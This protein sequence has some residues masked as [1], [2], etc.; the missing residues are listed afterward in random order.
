MGETYLS[1]LACT[2]RPNWRI[3]SRRSHRGFTHYNPKQDLKLFSCLQLA[4]N[5]HVGAVQRP[6]GVPL[7]N[8]VS[9]RVETAKPSEVEPHPRVGAIIRSFGRGKSRGE[10]GS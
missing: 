2:W 1:W 8:N 7:D 9:S 4:I 3:F 10:G 6:L 5:D